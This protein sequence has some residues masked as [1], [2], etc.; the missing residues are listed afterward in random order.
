MVLFSTYGS[1]LGKNAN[2]QTPV[3]LTL[4]ATRSPCRWGPCGCSTDPMR[5]EHAGVM[6]VCPQRPNEA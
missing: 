3:S 4:P 2:C 1:A 6:E 5:R